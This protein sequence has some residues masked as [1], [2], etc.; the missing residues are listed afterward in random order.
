MTALVDAS[1][2]VYVWRTTSASVTTL[3]G[4][5]QL[6][7]TGANSFTVSGGRIGVQVPTNA[8][9]DNFAGGTVP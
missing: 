1:G 4:S 8:R 5:V 9:V 6:P 2:M 3:L 7:T